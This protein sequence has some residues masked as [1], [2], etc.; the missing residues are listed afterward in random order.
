MVNGELSNQTG[1]KLSNQSRGRTICPV[2]G[3]ME[4]GPYARQDTWADCP[5]RTL[6]LHGGRR[7]SCCPMAGGD[8][9]VDVCK[10]MQRRCLAYDIKP[11]RGDIRA[12]DI[13][14]GYPEESM[15]CDLI[16]LDAP[17]WRLQKENYSEESV[18]NL[19]YRDWLSSFM[20]TLAKDAGPDGQT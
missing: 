16:F 19:S 3:K 6:S 15:N 10:I 1:A 11:P 9:T 2:C 8:T 4:S 13:R 20:E 17:Y 7:F 14:K 5:T 12:H 18:S